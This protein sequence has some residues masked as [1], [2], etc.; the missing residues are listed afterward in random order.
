M[1]GIPIEYRFSFPEKLSDFIKLKIIQKVIFINNIY[2]FT[3]SI[4]ILIKR[5]DKWLVAHLLHFLESWQGNLNYKLVIDYNKVFECMTKYT[6][7]TKATITKGMAS[8]I[9]RIL[10]KARDEGLNVQTV[11]KRTMAKLLGKRMIS[12]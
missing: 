4:E 7:K 11:L 12:K 3:Y 10:S 1:V 9:R 5:N 8:I 6:T 2:R